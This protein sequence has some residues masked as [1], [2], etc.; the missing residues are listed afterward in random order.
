M[1]LSLLMYVV[2]YQTTKAKQP[3]RSTRRNKRGKNINAYSNSK[4]VFRALHLTWANEKS[5]N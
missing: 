5:L 3:K 1:S 4:R 2:M